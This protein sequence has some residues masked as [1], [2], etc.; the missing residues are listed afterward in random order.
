MLISENI[1]IYLWIFVNQK[2][3]YNN[4]LYLTIDRIFVLIVNKNIFCD[5][6]FF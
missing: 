3:I 4:L 1:F 5:L 6:D 2:R